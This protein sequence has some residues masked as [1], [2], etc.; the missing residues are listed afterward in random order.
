MVALVVVFVVGSMLVGG[1]KSKSAAGDEGIR[2][3]VVPTADR[4]RTVVVPPCGTGTNITARNVA[5]QIETPGATVVQ[6]PQ[7]KRARVVL[8]PR[9]GASKSGAATAAQVPSS[10]FV[11]TIGAK[12]AAGTTGSAGA[13]TLQPKWQLI[14][15]TASQAQMVVV[16]PCTKGGRADR[17]TVLIPRAESPTALIA[18]R[19]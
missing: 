7:G 16:P 13:G 10:L 6:L 18:P 3:L 11:L 9:C 19:C 2:A 1:G 5:A 8:I 15:P 17:T 14:V 4:A 12:T